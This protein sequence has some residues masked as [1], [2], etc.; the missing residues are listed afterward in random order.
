[1][2]GIQDTFAATRDGRLNTDACSVCDW[3]H[4]G[5]IF[6]NVASFPS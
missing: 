1:M 6:S 2:R 4:H 5:L 3:D